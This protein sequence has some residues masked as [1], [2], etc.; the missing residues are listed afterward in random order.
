MALCSSDD[1]TQHVCE[2]DSGAQLEALDDGDIADLWVPHPTRLTVTH[3]LPDSICLLDHFGIIVAARDGGDT[4]VDKFKNIPAYAS[5][6]DLRERGV[7]EPFILA[8][9]ET[10]A[11]E[12]DIWMVMHLRYAAELRKVLGKRSIEFPANMLAAFVDS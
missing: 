1:I 12:N 5:F 2:I 3:E 6:Y 10:E 11:P 7:R 8:D 9:V 4:A